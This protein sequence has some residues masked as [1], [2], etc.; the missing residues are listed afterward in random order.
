MLIKQ[1]FPILHFP[2]ATT[3]TKL[4]FVTMDL[5][6]L[7]VS[8]RW[9]HITWFSLI[10]CIICK[11]H[12][13]CSMHQGF[14]SFLW[15][16]NISLYEFGFYIKYIDSTFCISFCLD[17][18]AFFFEALIFFF[19]M[20]A[21]LFLAE[22]RGGYGS[23]F[24]CLKQGSAYPLAIFLCSLFLCLLMF[25]LLIFPLISLPCTN[26]Q[27]Y[28]GPPFTQTIWNSYWQVYFLLLHRCFFFFFLSLINTMNVHDSERP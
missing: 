15:L 16:D 14:I 23:I 4:H 10:L 6:F 12:H 20:P 2:K 1:A 21:C 18:N 9:D 25:C 19:K 13:C 24:W 11:V 8:Y 5:P 28:V 22:G 17:K 7:D 26:L 3:A 27:V